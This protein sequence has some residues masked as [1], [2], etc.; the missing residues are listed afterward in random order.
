MS[1]ILGAHCVF[2]CDST[3]FLFPV[4]IT[5]NKFS[6]YLEW[7]TKSTNTALNLPTHDV[8]KEDGKIFEDQH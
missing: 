7:Q 4:I 8:S 6:L 2:I 3:A 1:Y 5:I